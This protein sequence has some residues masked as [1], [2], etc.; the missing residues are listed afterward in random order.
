MFFYEVAGFYLK[1]DP[2]QRLNI[3]LQTSTILTILK[4]EKASKN[5]GL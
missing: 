3:K 1:I 2:D 5:T 4:I